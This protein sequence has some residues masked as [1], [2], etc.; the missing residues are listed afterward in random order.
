MTNKKIL[1]LG[2]SAQQVIAIKKAK[3]LGYNTILCDYLPDNPGQYEADKF[4]Q[5]STTDKASVLNIAQKENINAIIAYAS[6]PAAPTAAYIAEKMNLKTNPYKSVEILCNKDLFKKF[7]LREGFNVPNSRGFDNKKTAIKEAMK[8]S[9]PIIIKPVDSSGSKGITV[10]KDNNRFEIEKAIDFAFGFSRNKRIIIENFIEKK[11]RYL[12]GGDIFVINGKI[13]IWG[14][15]NCHRDSNVNKLV[16]VGKSYPL[17]LEADD[18][19]NVK[20]TL[21]SI[22]DKLNIKNGPMNV[23][24]I[25][26]K[27]GKVWPIDIGP[28]SGG[29]MIPDLLNYVFGIDVVEMCIKAVDT[30]EIVKYEEKEDNNRFYATHNL[31]TSKNGILKDIVFDKKIEKYLIKK[32]IYKSIGDEVSFFDNAAKALGI[33]FF[34][35]SSRD[36]MMK[37]LENINEYISIE[38]E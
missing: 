13:S 14:L 1:L 28:R 2:G 35:F 17:E 5:V 16:P 33:I 26:D 9:F 4:Y 30:N 31:H 37:Y 38:V 20:I 24:L 27:F 36:E 12:I 8:Y 11:H 19:N 18:L 34:K 23:E 22:V 32:C 6:D 21:Q 15:L 10:I 7:L 3:E 29:N 25:V